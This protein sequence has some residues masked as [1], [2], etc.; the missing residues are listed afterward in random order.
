MHPVREAWTAAGVTPRTI[1]PP[2]AV[3]LMPALQR[4]SIPDLPHLGSLRWIFFMRQ[5]MLEQY[6]ARVG[7][8]LQERCQSR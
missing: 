1:R 4:A 7:P 3:Y 8:S 5:P 6:A 2:S